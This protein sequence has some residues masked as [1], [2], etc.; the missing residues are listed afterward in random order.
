MKSKRFPLAAVLACLILIA[1]CATQGDLD[2]VQRDANNLTK[3][4]ISVQR[5][6]YELN[7]EMK[8]FSGKVAALE[9]KV[10]DLQRETNKVSGDVNS[11]M[12]MLQKEIDTSSQP[13]RRY[14]ADL[15]A[16]IDKLQTDVQNLGGRFEE[17]K[18]FAEK[19]FGATKSSQTR[20]DELEKKVAA[21]QKSLEGSPDRTLLKI[22]VEKGEKGDEEKT[23]AGPEASKE[24]PA[25]PEKT[26]TAKAPSGPDDL[27]KR[28]YDRYSKGDL[29][30][31]RGD[32][33][34]FLDAYPKSKY[35]E[36]AHFWLG[37]CYFGQKKYEDAIL[38][39]DEVIKRFPKGNKVPDALYRQGMAFLEM[40]DTTNAKLILKEVVRRFPQSDQATRA[41]KKLKDIG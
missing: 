1:S 40:K 27:Y 3:E 26:A 28:A 13:M 41:R 4:L 10:A 24:T 30:G 16:R 9:K 31:A 21:L 17:S 35:A 2:T 22:P 23:P 7:G 36:N 11:R 34:K 25:A 37:E 15:G 20:L 14:Q 19:T 5:N 38:E 12:G 33:K 39:Y 8:D 18:Y 32:F 6:V 29:E